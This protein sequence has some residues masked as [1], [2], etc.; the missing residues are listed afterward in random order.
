M[1]TNTVDSWAKKST[2]NMLSNI[3][4]S[5]F[6]GSSDKTITFKPLIFGGTFPIDA[7]TGIK[8]IKNKAN[9]DGYSAQM[10]KSDSHKLLLNEL[11]Q[12]RKYGTPKTYDIDRPI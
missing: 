9:V 3:K 7:P 11:P 2:K 8:P 1:I 5:L 10:I 12:V 4:N 6:K